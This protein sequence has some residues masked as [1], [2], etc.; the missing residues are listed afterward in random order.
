MSRQWAVGG[1]GQAPHFFPAPSP[2]PFLAS[3][4]PLPYCPLPLQSRTPGRQHRRACPAGRTRTVRRDPKRVARGGEVLAGSAKAPRDPRVEERVE[5]RAEA[6]WD[7]AADTANGPLVHV[8]AAVVAVA[9]HPPLKGPGGLHAADG[10]QG[11]PHGSFL[12]VLHPPV[13]RRAYS[14]SSPPPDRRR[15]PVARGIPAT[16]G[17]GRTGRPARG[18]NHLGDDREEPRD[19]DHEE[20]H[21]HPAKASIFVSRSTWWAQHACSQSTRSLSP[22]SPRST[23]P[24]TL[25][26]RAPP[27]SP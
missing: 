12:L 1:I 13:M 23:L 20:Q 3:P 7:A 5:G 4:L 9:D 2:F 15:R 19:G 10:W 8:L 17:P 27:R 24:A 14:I 6:R 26:T 18:G 22:P 25:R 16:P 11:L 21:Q